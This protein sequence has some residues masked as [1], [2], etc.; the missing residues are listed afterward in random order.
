MKSFTSVIIL[1]VSLLLLVSPFVCAEGD[2]DYIVEL[3]MEQEEQQ[4]F[5][6]YRNLSYFTSEPK[7]DAIKSFSVNDQ[8][9]VAVGSAERNIVSVYNRDGDFQYGYRFSCDGTFGVDWNQNNLIIYFVRGN[10]AV[11]VDEVGTIL[12][13]YEIKSTKNQD[14]KYENHLFYYKKRS[15]EKVYVMKNDSAFLN[16]I[17]SKYSKLVCVDEIGNEKCIY[18]ADVEKNMLNNV[19]QYVYFTIFVFITVVASLLFT[20]YCFKKNKKTGDGSVSS[21]EK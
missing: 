8:G 4:C 3:D 15:N 18:F 14:F 19:M 2:T 13:I 16:F 11:E 10:K 6:S 5:L 7:K 9:M 17:S 1:F 12:K 20:R 21:R